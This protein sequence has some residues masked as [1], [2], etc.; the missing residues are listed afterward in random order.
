MYFIAETELNYHYI[1]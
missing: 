1:R